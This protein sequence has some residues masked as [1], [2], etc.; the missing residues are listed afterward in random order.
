MTEYWWSKYA[1]CLEHRNSPVPWPHKRA[2]MVAEG[3]ELLAGALIYDTDGPHL[4]AE[5]LVTNQTATLRSRHLAVALMAQELVRYAR[6]VG[7]LPHVLVRHKGI[8]KILRSVGMVPS[9]AWSLTMGMD[10]LDG[11]EITQEA[12]ASE[13]SSGAEPCSECAEGI[14]PGNEAGCPEDGP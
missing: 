12:R 7:K 1:E 11:R 10:K 4:F 9:G 2:I 8:E 6:T 13:G 14:H 3:T 5:H